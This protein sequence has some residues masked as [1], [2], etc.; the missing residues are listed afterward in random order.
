ME[1]VGSSFE[2]YL[3][4]RLHFTGLVYT[5]SRYYFQ[6]NIIILCSE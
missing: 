2:N 3:T 5:F 6:F 4:D 1:Q